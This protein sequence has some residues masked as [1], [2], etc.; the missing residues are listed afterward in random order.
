VRA[1]E[2]HSESREAF[3][4]HIPGLKM[5]IPSGPR[6][7]RALLISAIRDPDPVIF[8]EGKAIYRAFREE[9]PE[10]EETLPI[11]KAQ[12]VLEGEDLTLISYGAMMRP[13]LEAAALLKEKDGVEAE[14]IDLLTISPL[15]ETTLVESVKKTGRAVVVH[16]APRSFGPGAEVVSRLMEKAFFYLEAPIARVTGFDIVIPLFSKEQAYLPNAQ[17]IIRAARKV[18][19]GNI[20]DS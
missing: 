8:Y 4:A 5:V 19:A 20:S 15:D 13:T 11:G 18:M 17:R 14:V 6:N 12:R 9:V 2:H 1:L 16:E 7:A 10:A 3:W